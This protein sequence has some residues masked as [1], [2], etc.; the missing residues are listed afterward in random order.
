MRLW[1]VVLLSDVVVL[2]EPRRSRPRRHTVH[3]MPPRS[4]PSPRPEATPAGAPF[5]AREADLVKAVIDAL[6]PIFR[7]DG[8]DVELVD[9]ASGHVRLRLSGACGGCAAASLTL[10][11]VRL[12][13]IEALGR[14]VRVLPVMGASG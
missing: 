9:L 14:P 2:E 5:S 8:G 13:L 6:R 12:K 3:V 11:G 7:R 1:A 4:A 10:G